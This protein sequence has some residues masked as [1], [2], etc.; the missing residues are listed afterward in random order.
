[1]LDDLDKELEQRGHKFVR[2]ANDCNIYVKTER[3]GKRVMRSMRQFLEKKLKLAVNLAKSKV[4]R[5]Q[6]VKFLGFIFYKRKGEVLIRVTSKTL[7]RCRERIRR[8][9]KRT[10]SGKLEQVIPE[11]HRYMMGWIGYFRQANAPAVFEKL[12]EWIRR[13]LR[14]LVWKRWKRG[15][16]RYRKL[17]ALGVPRDRA[18]L[19]AAGT[20]PWRMSCTP[21]VHEALN[22]AYW[23]KSGL[24]SIAERYRELRLT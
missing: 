20:S 19:G 4:E 10:R 16:T 14:Q 18:A 23:R 6:W 13:R 22:N 8:L 15:K 21:V 17:V 24:R 9:T 11:I 1:M 2:Y 7:A 3:A 12:D 5:A